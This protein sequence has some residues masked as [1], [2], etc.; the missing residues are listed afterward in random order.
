MMCILGP[1]DHHRDDD[2]DLSD[3]T[4]LVSNYNGILLY[5]HDMQYITMIMMMMMMMMFD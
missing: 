2:I 5:Y 1:F 3:P 4:V